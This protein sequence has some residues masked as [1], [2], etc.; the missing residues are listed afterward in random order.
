V[1]LTPLTGTECDGVKV[2]AEPVPKSPES[3]RDN[4]TPK[5]PTETVAD[6]PVRATVTSGDAG[7]ARLM[8]G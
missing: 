6:T 8:I 7:T 2:P 5:V 3:A 1:E 4:A